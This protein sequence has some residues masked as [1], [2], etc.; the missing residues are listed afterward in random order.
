MLLQAVNCQ[1]INPLATLHSLC[2]EFH[3]LGFEWQ[4]EGGGGGGGTI[5]AQQKLSNSENQLYCIMYCIIIIEHMCFS[6]QKSMWTNQ[7]CVTFTIWLVM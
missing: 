6:L 2:Y 3:A 5:E 1:I 7:I 4:K